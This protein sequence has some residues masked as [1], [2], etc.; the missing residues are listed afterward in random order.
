MAEI[1]LVSSHTPWAPLPQVVAPAALRDG[2]VFTAIHAAADT[3]EDV[4]RDPARVRAAYAASVVY[5]I[6]SLVSF[7]ANAQDDNLVL[8][9]LGDHQPTTVVSG[10]GASHDVPVAVVAHDP[11]VLDR[12]SGWR[13]QD[14]MTPRPD[15]PVWPM[16]AFRDRFLTA[17]G[18]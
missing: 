7:V 17:Y 9:I 6:D 10:V 2:S 13:W 5:T 3:P 8:I 14:G 15:A 12:I 1:D 11:A 16:E 18:G 4:W